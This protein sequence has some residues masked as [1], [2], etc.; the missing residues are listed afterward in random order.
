MMIQRDRNYVLRV[1][2]LGKQT[3]IITGLNISFR[4]NKSVDNKRRGNQ[5]SVSI[6]NL[7]KENRDLLED[8][9]VFVSLDVGYTETGLHELFSGQVTWVE[10]KRQRNDLVT[11]L[12]LDTLYSA[13]N[14]RLI[15]GLI[16]PGADLQTTLK[17]VASEIPEVVQTKFVGTTLQRKLPD[18]YPYNGTPRQVLT[19]ICSAYGLEWQID[20]DTLTITDDGF[21]TM[22]NSQAFVLNERSGLL[23]TP[24]IDEVQKPRV[25]RKKGDTSPRPRGKRGL[26]IKCLLNPVFK[27]GG[28]VRLE[29]GDLTGYYK[30]LEIVHNGEIYGNVWETELSCIPAKE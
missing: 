14:N 23:D 1:G 7:S 18:G 8:N 10:T 11:T 24:R 25:H 19:D 15:G 2:E 20:G 21:S 29:F 30:I 22:T 9:K 5:A 17:R 28:L 13:L 27:A 6:Y 16:A 26:S 3:I 4:V 12:T